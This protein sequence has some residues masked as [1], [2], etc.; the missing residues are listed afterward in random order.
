LW[1]YCTEGGVENAQLALRFAAHLIGGRSAVAG[2]A[3]AA[4]GFWRG[5]PAIDNR[6]NAIV[7]FYRRWS[8]AAI[9][10]RSMRCARRWT[11]AGSTP[12]VS[13]SPV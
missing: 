2:A 4:A 9:P 3:D 5:E 13:M 10:R 11:R 6:P 1:R 7:I 12:C 8:P